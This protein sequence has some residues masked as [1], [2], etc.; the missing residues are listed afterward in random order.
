[1]ERMHTPEERLENSFSNVYSAEP[2]T[3]TLAEV[4]RKI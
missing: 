2:H 3:V 1:M 4:C